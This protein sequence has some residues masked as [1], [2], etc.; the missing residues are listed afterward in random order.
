MTKKIITTIMIMVFA[1]CTTALAKDFRPQPGQGFGPPAVDGTD[2]DAS[3]TDTSQKEMRPRPPK[4]PQGPLSMLAKV[5]QDNIAAEV[6]AAITGQ[7]VESI[8]EAL[9]TQHMRELLESYEIEDEAFKDAMDEKAAAFIAQAVENGSITQEQADTIIQM[10]EERPER[11]E[12]P[13]RPEPGAM[14]NQATEL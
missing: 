6:L 2:N 9:Q 8:T 3:G 1:L 7:T 10:M 4:G 5:Q 12:R 13:E 11:S 14:D